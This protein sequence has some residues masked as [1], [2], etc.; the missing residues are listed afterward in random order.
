MKEILLKT[1]KLHSEEKHLKELDEKVA[2]RK[3]SESQL[4]EARNH[5]DVLANELQ[6]M[7][8]ATLK[9]SFV[10]LTKAYCDMYSNGLQHMN[11]QLAALGASPSQVKKSLIFDF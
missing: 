2:K 1:E 4:N 5:R 8:E 10:N 6:R 11:K 9:D 3:A 7:K